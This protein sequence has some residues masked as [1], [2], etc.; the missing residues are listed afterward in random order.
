M[1]PNPVQIRRRTPLPVMAYAVYLYFSGLSLRRAARS[2]RSI[3]SRSHASIWRWVQRLGPILGS[4]GA[5]PRE[6]R[7]IFVDETMVDLGRPPL[8][9]REEVMPPWLDVLRPILS[10]G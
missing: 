10:L 2:L 7:R 9:W 4:I 5:D 1:I 3:V 6:V 8:G